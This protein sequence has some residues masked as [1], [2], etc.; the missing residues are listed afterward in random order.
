MALTPG[1][2]GLHRA[3]EQV[4]GPTH[5]L[6]DPDLVA[7]YLRDWTGR[8]T[9]HTAAVV[10]PGSVEEVQEVVRVCHEHAVPLVPQGGNTGLVGGS[11]PHRGEVVVSLRRL[12]RLGPVDRQTRQVTVGAGV[13]VAMVEAHAREAG[14]SYGVDLA[15]RDSA[16]IGGTIATNAGG[17]NVVAYGDTRQQLAG[18]EVV[19][20]DGELVSDLGGVEKVSTGPDILEL[21]VGSEGS[22]GVI[23]SA[24]L[25]L[26]APPI[27]ERMVSLVAVESLAEGLRYRGPGVTALEFFSRRCLEL[28]VA[29]RSVPRPL[30]SDAP[31]YVLVESGDLPQVADSSAAV[32]DPRLWVYREA[33]TET[34]SRV[35]VPVKLDVALPL[36]KLDDFVSAIDELGVEGDVYLYG[37]LAEGN[38]HVNVL[39]APDPARVEDQVLGAVVALEGAI[40]SEHGIGVAKAAW[41]RRSTDSALVEANRRI[42]D[43]LDPKGI[44]NPEVFWGGG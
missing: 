39:G 34:I 5:A 7:G 25:R 12:D 15:S 37:H 18:L 3:L 4:V 21:M 22:L 42:K 11:V 33:I 2:R 36:S 38:F 1:T 41:W 14:L 26:L 23:T 9:G 44:L 32:V 30:A 27:G 29:H 20:S 31:F 10:R 43:A 17:M 19:L 6:V 35:G 40:A 16:T 13:T 24:R 28:V 8:W